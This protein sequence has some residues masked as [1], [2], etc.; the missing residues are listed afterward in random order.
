VL[1][2]KGRR[3]ALRRYATDYA[4]RLERMARAFPMQWYNFFG[5]WAH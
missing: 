2:R 1:D 3:D 5:F 4:A